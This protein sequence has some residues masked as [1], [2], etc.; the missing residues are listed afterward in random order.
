MM[1]GM[2]TKKNKRS[3]SDKL[4]PGQ[5]YPLW[6][7]ENGSLFLPQH[8]TAQLNVSRLQHSP[9]LRHVVKVSRLHL[10]RSRSLLL[11]LLERS[12]GAVGF[13]TAKEYHFV[14]WLSALLETCDFGA[15][16]I[17]LVV[18]SASED[19][20]LDRETVLRYLVR[21]TSAGSEFRSDGHI[22][23]FRR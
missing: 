2:V 22:I 11:W 21:Q 9:P 19:L 20:A 12:S 14:T 23:T 17:T 18:R 1:W 4:V 15:A 16:E 7:D 5:H 8:S 10:P 6:P 3:K 13:G